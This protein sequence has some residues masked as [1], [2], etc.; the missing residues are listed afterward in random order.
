MNISCSLYLYNAFYFLILFFVNLHYLSCCIKIR[1]IANESRMALVYYVNLIDI[2]IFYIHR[3]AN[4]EFKHDQ[5]L[6]AYH[7]QKSGKI[8]VF[9]TSPALLFIALDLCPLSLHLVSSLYFTKSFL[10]Q[11]QIKIMVSLSSNSRFL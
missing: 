10:K 6:Q 3:E 2:I 4:T 1:H 11:H 5:A 8:L 7:P 9:F